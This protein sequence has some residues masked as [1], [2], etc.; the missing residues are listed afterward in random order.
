MANSTPGGKMNRKSLLAG[1]A[2]AGFAAAALPAAAQSTGPYVGASLGQATAKQVCSGAA[3]C[4]KDETAVKGFAGYQFNRNL[5]AEAGY[6]YFGM[7]GRNNAGISTSAFDVVAVGTYPIPGMSQLAAYGKLGLY[8][9]SMKS[10][11]LSEDSTGLTYVLGAEYA[12]SRDIG[13]RGE[14]Q[15]YKN[16]GGGS[17][18][19]TTDIEVLAAGVVWRP[20]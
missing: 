8:M 6:Q 5:A 10:K 4:D 7:F 17:L 14:W 9:S 18:G 3:T 20:H 1:I 13:L 11:P 2:F 16:L 12:V 19:F 15:R